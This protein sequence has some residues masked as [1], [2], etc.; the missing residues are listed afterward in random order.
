[1][2][3]TAVPVVENCLQIR[4]LKVGYSVQESANNGG[5]RHALLM[6]LEPLFVISVRTKICDNTVRRT[7]AL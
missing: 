1:M 5:T 7:P 2:F 6:R 4:L 3:H